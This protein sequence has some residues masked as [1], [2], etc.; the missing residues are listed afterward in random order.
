MRLPVIPNRLLETW[1]GLWAALAVCVFVATV[2]S[3]TDHEWCDPGTGRAP[4]SDAVS[5]LSSLLSR[6][7]LPGRG[8]LGTEGANSGLLAQER[9]R[10]HTFGP[11]QSDPSGP[12]F[13]V[14]LI[15]MEVVDLP[16]SKMTHLVETGLPFVHR[17]RL[18]VIFKP[19][20]STIRGAS[21]F[22]SMI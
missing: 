1:S 21:S 3:Q 9:F 22:R 10:D 16:P 8:T 4:S 14:G 13:S 6:Q 12:S 2:I 11:G 15:T 5:A 19:P 17:L 18:G 20:I 7:G